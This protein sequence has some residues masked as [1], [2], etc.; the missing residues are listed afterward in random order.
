MIDHILLYHSRIRA[1]L[2]GPDLLYKGLKM[3]C[4]IQAHNRIQPC[5]H[6]NPRNLASRRDHQNTVY[7]LSHCIDFTHNQDQTCM[8]KGI[9]SSRVPNLGKSRSLLAWY[10]MSRANL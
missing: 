5:T 10:P 3:T 6:Q 7:R 1:G 9:T 2:L 8:R 4:Q